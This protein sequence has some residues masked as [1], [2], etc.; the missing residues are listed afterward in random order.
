MM[1]MNEIPCIVFNENSKNNSESNATIVENT[2][3][4]IYDLYGKRVCYQAKLDFEF[5]LR[6]LLDYVTLIGYE[7]MPKVY[8]LKKRDDFTKD[9]EMVVYYFNEDVITILGLQLM[10]DNGS[11]EYSVIDLVTYKRGCLKN[12]QCLVYDIDTTYGERIFNLNYE[13]SNLEYIIPEDIKLSIDY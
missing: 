7:I 9:D 5:K 1:K 11:E 12:K 3:K 4:E 2:L 13:L 10:V 8:K 6:Q